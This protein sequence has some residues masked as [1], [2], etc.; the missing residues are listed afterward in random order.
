MVDIWSNIGRLYVHIRPRAGDKC[1][2]DILEQE[3]DKEECMMKENTI[4][5]SAHVTAQRMS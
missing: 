4:N 2:N 3:D 5:I 1:R